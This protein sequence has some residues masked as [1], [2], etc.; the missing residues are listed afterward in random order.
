VTETFR[1]R[2]GTPADSR[3]AFDVFLPAIRDL[4]ARQGVPWDPDPATLWPR[5]QPML[6][7]LAAHAAEWWVAEDTRSE[8]MIGYARSIE[9]GGLFE[10]SE[11]FVHPERQSAG[12]GSALL[13]AAFP[14]GRGEVRAIIA[15]CDMRAQSRY[16]R[17]GTVARF[18]IV[19]L[20]GTPDPSAHD[21]ADPEV[22]IVNAKRE[23][24]PV[25]NEIEAA[26]I[27][28]PRGDEF[29]WLLEHREGYLYRRGGTPFGFA[30]VSR[31]GMGPMAA[32]TPDD[33]LPILRHVEA[34]SA[35]LGMKELSLEVPM[36]NEVA[37]RHLLARGYRMDSFLTLLMS[38]R[39]FGS[40]D[41]FIGFQPPFVL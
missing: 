38:S 31:D 19:A 27:E 16:Y 3:A 23:D 7:H 10:L 5:L 21:G 12:V 6:D 2:R 37:V 13:E 41:R 40:F 29:H 20:A 8:K 26:A 36:V 34:R 39:P 32:R 30:F 25:L 35:A 22:E 9:R 28:F 15:T 33:Q 1:L 11:F 17:A 18:P 24:V 4:T 14:T